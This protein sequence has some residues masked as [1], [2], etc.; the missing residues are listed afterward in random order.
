METAD[1]E[2]LGGRNGKRNYCGGRPEKVQE[3][4]FY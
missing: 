3:L 2:V 4:R 1:L